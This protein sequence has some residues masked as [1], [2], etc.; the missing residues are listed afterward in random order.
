VA[1]DLEA[2]FTRE[3]IW[4]DKGGQKDFID[5]AAFF[6]NGSEIGSV[7]LPIDLFVGIGSRKNGI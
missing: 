2:V 1:T 3:R 6:S 5:A 4:G 7:S